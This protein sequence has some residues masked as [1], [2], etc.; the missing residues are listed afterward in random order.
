MFRLISQKIRIAPGTKVIKEKDYTLYLEASEIIAKAEERAMQIE[1]DAKRAYEEKKQEGYE[2]GLLEGKMEYGEKMLDT[3][4]AAIDFL[5]G[6][7]EK[8]AKLVSLAVK[9]IIGE[10]ENDEIILRVIKNALL[11]VHS[12][13][14]VLLKISPQD[15]ESVRNAL[16][17]L[18]SASDVSFNYIDIVVDLRMNQGDCVLESDL[19]LLDASLE[20]QLK[21]LENALLKKIRLN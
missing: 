6:F 2:D 4:I 5:E 7:E 18:S 1:N 20:T 15:E 21:I 13:Q 10:L 16:G 12:Q 8:M 9:K 17:K 3:T 19:G 11:Q 14:K